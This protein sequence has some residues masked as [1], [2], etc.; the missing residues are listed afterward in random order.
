MTILYDPAEKPKR[1]GP[2]PVWHHGSK[3]DCRWTH[4]R[5][6]KGELRFVFAHAVGDEAYVAHV[7]DGQFKRLRAD[8]FASFSTMRYAVARRAA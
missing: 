2:M 1:V 4:Y 6:G 3:H 5:N 7:F 8:E